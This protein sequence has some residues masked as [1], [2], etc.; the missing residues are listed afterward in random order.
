MCA[1]KRC[2]AGLPASPRKT[3]PRA[4]YNP[5]RLPWPGPGGCPRPLLSITGWACR[6][7]HTGD[8]GTAH[9]SRGPTLAFG[10]RMRKFSILGVASPSSSGGACSPIRLRPS[11]GRSFMVMNGLLQEVR[12]GLR[13]LL[14]DFLWAKPELGSMGLCVWS[15]TGGQGPEDCVGPLPH[16]PCRFALSLYTCHSL[17]PSR[18]SYI[19][20]LRKSLA[21]QWTRFSFMS[22][23]FPVP[24]HPCAHRLPDT[25][26]H[27]MQVTLASSKE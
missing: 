27:E 25:C 3:G 24:R 23:W 22:F 12:A 8:R 19:P 4:I 14:W 10:H 17:S 16:P 1:A 15:L 21:I 2:V 5:T 13:L 11:T 6:Q 26:T 7:A 20:G 18:S 9:R